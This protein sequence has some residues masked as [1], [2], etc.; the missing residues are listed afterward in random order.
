MDGQT[1]QVTAPEDVVQMVDKTKDN[2][3]K[4]VGGTIQKTSVV[5][6]GRVTDKPEKGKTRQSQF[7]KSRQFKIMLM[8]NT[9]VN[10]FLRQSSLVK[11]MTLKLILATKLFP[12]F[13]Y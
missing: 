10:P 9:K 6:E 2:I 11:L 5:P 12:L 8:I 3:E 1:P 7:F 13:R 4:A